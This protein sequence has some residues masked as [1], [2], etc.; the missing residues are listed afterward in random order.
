MVSEYNLH[1]KRFIKNHP[2]M[3][4]KDA[5]SAA[6]AE[7]RAMKKGSGIKYTGDQYAKWLRDQK[8]S[9]VVADRIKPLSGLGIRRKRVI[10]SLMPF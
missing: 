6:A 7:W 5:F 4:T 8:G 10:G 2:N 3:K 9:Q 1:V